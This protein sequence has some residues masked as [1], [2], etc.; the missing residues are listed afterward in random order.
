MF[1][2]YPNSAL[3]VFTFPLKPVYR[4]SVGGET[5]SP[6]PSVGGKGANRFPHLHSTGGRL[7]EQ[8]SSQF[9]AAQFSEDVGPGS[10]ECWP[11]YCLPPTSSFFPCKASNCA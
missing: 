7:T 9:E 4:E 10:S 1:L 11:S 3:I 5:S 8:S 2:S 6:T